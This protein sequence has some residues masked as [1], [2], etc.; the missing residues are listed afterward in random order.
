MNDDFLSL[1]RMKPSDLALRTPFSLFVSGPSQ[2]GKTR[3]TQRIIKQAEVFSSPI[4]NVVYAYSQWQPV[5]QEIRDNDLSVVFLEGLPTM[6]DLS[7][8]SEKDG[9]LLLVLDDL[10]YRVIQSFD[11]MDLFTIHVHHM[12]ISVIFVSVR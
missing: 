6:D 12:N 1:L 3:F 4:R 2:S 7:A 5:F 11:Y 9:G 8:W 10:V